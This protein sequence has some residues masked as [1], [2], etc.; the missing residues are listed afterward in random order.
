MA[1]V[2]REKARSTYDAREG[3]FAEEEVCAALVL[4]NL[5]ECERAGT[6]ATLLA[7]T[8]LAVGI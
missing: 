1:L 4:A 7:L 5:A 2:R 6:I 3:E 8:R